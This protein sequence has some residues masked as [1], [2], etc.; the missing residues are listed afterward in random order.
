MTDKETPNPQ[1]LEASK[2]QR[3]RENQRRC[4]T[5]KKEYIASL[6]ARLRELEQKG[7]QASITL[8]QQA[9]RVLAE[10]RS[11][12]SLLTES[13][14]MSTEDIDAY[15]RVGG[16]GQQ[17]CESVPS[18]SGSRQVYAPPAAAISEVSGCCKRQE[19]EPLAPCGT[20]SSPDATL[21][22]SSID[23]LE[24]DVQ[25]SCDQ[26]YASSAPALISIPFVAPEPDRHPRQVTDE[27]PVLF[28]PILVVTSNCSI[29]PPTQ[30]S[31][32]GEGA[33][34]LDT[35]AVLP[36]NDV[37][38][39]PQQLMADQ[40]PAEVVSDEAIMTVMCSTPWPFPPS[41]SKSYTSCTFAYQL[42]SAIN[43][44]RFM[45]MNMHDVLIEWLWYG[46]RASDD[47]ASRCCVVDDGVLYSVAVNL[48]Q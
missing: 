43:Q 27:A 48:L 28:D 10:N 24:R 9:R 38:L 17:G 32:Q 36:Y 1:A 40:P 35:P 5:R 42:L 44:R 31:S 37:P 16:G 47:P 4:R 39:I 14:H 20:T 2:V 19:S 12:R 7:A 23:I 33:V 6:E 26:G 22:S 45:P 25:Q 34:S 13:F 15:L 30:T 11:L 41:P 29:D 3:V 8:Q 21:H 46:F 18:V